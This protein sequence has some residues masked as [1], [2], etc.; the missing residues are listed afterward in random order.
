MGIYIFIAAVGALTAGAPGAVMDWSAG[1]SPTAVALI[2]TLLA[3][4][5]FF[6]WLWRLIVFGLAFFSAPLELG[7]YGPFFLFLTVFNVPT[8][9]VLGF[10][11]PMKVGLEKAF[12]LCAT[13]TLA[14]ENQHPL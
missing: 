4:S 6:N 13:A 9:A 11:K 7:P 12:F 1:A 14:S 10:R 5:F 8:F 2:V 3:G